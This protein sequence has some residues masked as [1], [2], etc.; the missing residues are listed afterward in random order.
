MKLYKVFFYNCFL[1]LA[2]VRCTGWWY[3]AVWSEILHNISPEP[4]NQ[5][6]SNLI[7]K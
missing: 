6:N 7:L 1:V 5:N 4:V 2:L 3:V